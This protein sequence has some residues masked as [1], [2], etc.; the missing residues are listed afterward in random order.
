[1]LSN[2]EVTEGSVI[3]YLDNI[4]TEYLAVWKDQKVIPI[5]SASARKKAETKR[6]VDV[7]RVADTSPIP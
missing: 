1:M 4:E 5:L 7:M 3:V 6:Q 2:K